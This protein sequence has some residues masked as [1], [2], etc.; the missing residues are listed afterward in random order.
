MRLY[1]VLLT[2]RPKAPTIMSV[3][4]LSK[5]QTLRVL[6]CK[7]LECTRVYLN[8]RVFKLEHKPHQTE[9]EILG[10][11]H[12]RR[13]DKLNYVNLSSTCRLFG[14]TSKKWSFDCFCILR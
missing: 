12:G 2:Y 13:R 14:E 1:Y 8:I 11:Q 10:F 9:W 4:L 6:R 3:L 7:A 5:Q